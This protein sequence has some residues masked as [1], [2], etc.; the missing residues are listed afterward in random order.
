MINNRT[1]E[2]S[3]LY[4]MLW[5]FA[6]ERHQ[7]YIKRLNNEK[8]P[9]TND[10]IMRDFKFTN[11]YR[12][13]D[14]TSQY[15]IKHIINCKTK[16]SKKDLFFRILMFKI[17]NKIET[18][19]ALE[20]ELGEVSYSKFNL[21]RYD[22]I[23]TKLMQEGKRIYS[24]AYIMPSG[25][26][27]FGDSIKHRNNLRL[28]DMIMNDNPIK[29]LK[30]M[31]TLEDLYLYL[32]KFPTIGPFLAFQY[33]I[34]INYSDLCDFSEMDFVVAGPGAIRGIQKCFKGIKKGDF[35]EV[36]RYVTL[37]Q[38]TEFRKRNIKFEYVYNRKLQLIDVQNIFC[39]ID[40]YSRQFTIYNPNN[41]R[42]KQKYKQNLLPVSNE[43]PNKWNKGDRY[44]ASHNSKE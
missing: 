4:D 33:A 15:L 41:S 32:L 12:F 9:W 20:R 3:D 40:K 10:N 44:S 2:T 13:L 18:W 6:Y 7:I 30:K 37:N 27:S 8:V 34:D 36:I 25:K 28:I 39:E 5:Y 43:I 22:E 11:V 19:E 1:L 21:D 14:R 42:I 29:A 23:L 24:A 17:F 38:E 26:T 35:S 16:Y 31:N